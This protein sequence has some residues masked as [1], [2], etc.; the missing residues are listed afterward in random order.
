MKDLFNPLEFGFREWG[1]NMHGQSYTNDI[2]ELRRVQGVSKLNGNA[3]FDY[4]SDEIAPN[5]MWK[6]KFKNDTKYIYVGIIPNKRFA[7]E[8]LRN[9]N[10]LPEW[11]LCDCIKRR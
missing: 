9:T 6:L 3:R 11:A 10:S 1:T 2:A 4:I 5:D 8:L 7:L